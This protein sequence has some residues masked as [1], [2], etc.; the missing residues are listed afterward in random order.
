M[1][2]RVIESFIPLLAKLNKKTTFYLVPQKWNDYS[3]TT[4]YELYAN[5]IVKEPL[6]SYLIGSV[7][8]MKSGL[9][10]KTYPLAIDTDFER[11]D[12]NFCS[13]GQSTDYY[14]NLNR[15]VP[16]YKNG[17]LESLRDIVTSPDLKPL[18]ED[19]DVFCL[20][21]MRDFH[22]RPSLLEEINCI[23]QQGKP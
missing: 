16:A 10:K 15:L 5:Q 2:I 8:I 4:T 6:D 21:L 13:L 3:Y 17:L 23:C 22:E 19:E 12:E 14:S 1:Q 18:Y 11:L 20:S 7:K 9:K